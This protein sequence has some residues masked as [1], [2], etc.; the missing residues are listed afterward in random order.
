M[1]DPQQRLIHSGD[2]SEMCDVLSD[3]KGGREGVIGE[4]INGFR[5]RSAAY[6]IG[7]AY[8]GF[9]TRE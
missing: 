8:S 4:K 5:A 3:F 7:A 6:R 9:L 2:E 1:L